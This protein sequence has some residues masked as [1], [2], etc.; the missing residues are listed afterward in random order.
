MKFIAK[1]PDIPLDI[2]KALDDD[3]LVFFCG[4][5][6]SYKA[7]FNGFRW[8]VESIYKNLGENIN[9]LIRG[10]YWTMTMKIGSEEFKS[11]SLQ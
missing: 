4:A 9:L 2:L 3:N 6:V 8:L 10:L 5:G 1:G 11:K 7:G